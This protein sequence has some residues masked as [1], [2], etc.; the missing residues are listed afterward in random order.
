MKKYI[1]LFVAITLLG[2]GAFFTQQWFIGS[3]PAENVTQTTDRDSIT[4]TA[5]TT[6][7]V[8]DVMHALTAEGTFSFSGR[9]Y[10]SLGFFVESIQ[11]KKNAGGYYWFLYVNGKESEKGASQTFLSPTDTVEWKYKKG[12]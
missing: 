6:G 10:P 11:G 12:Y 9:E 5:T 1:L 7:S 4:F 8:L 3:F 2:G